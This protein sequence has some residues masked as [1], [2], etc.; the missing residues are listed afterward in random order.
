MVL[1]LHRILSAHS[2]TDPTSWF[3]TLFSA[4]GTLTFCKEIPVFSRACT[5]LQ[6][7]SLNPNHTVVR[8]PVMI[9]RPRLHF[10]RY[11]L[12]VNSDKFT[13]IFMDCPTQKK[14]GR[15]KQ[16]NPNQRLLCLTKKKKK[17]YAPFESKGP[18]ADFWKVA[19][20]MGVGTERYF[21]SPSRE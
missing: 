19:G 1:G 8:S 20:E 9:C 11:F 21:P 7:V 12:L 16:Q 4:V 10:K 17:D 18:E 2:F 13:H 14:G 3:R 6:G 5:L 15:K